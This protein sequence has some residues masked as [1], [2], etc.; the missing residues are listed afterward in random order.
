MYAS[1]AGGKENT[2]QADLAVL[3]EKEMITTLNK[4]CQLKILW[5]TNN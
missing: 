3:Q 4:L 5:L 2:R 1:S